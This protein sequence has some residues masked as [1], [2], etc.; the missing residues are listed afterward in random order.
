MTT[1]VMTFD[2]LN[3]GDVQSLLDEAEP[4]GAPLLRCAQCGH[5]VA[6]PQSRTERE[7]RHEHRCENPRGLVFDIGCFA[8]AP[9]CV[10]VGTA[11]DEHSWFPGYGWRIA[12]CERC[13]HHLGWRFQ[14]A[15]DQFFGLIL[16][17][18]KQAG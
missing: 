16:S 2:I 13:H 9:G 6:D 1:A 7:G 5:G 17:N 11:T 8:S 18:L 15:G 12:I 3:E 14:S 4:A 10:P